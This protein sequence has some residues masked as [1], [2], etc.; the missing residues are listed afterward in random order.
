LPPVPPP[1]PEDVIATGALPSVPLP[2]V[3]SEPPAPARPTEPPER[4]TASTLSLTGI[5][6]PVPP[7]RPA[8]RIEVAS[9]GPVTI[10]AGPPVEVKPQISSEQ[11]DQLRALFAGSQIAT[12]A[13]ARASRT[14]SA[15]AGRDYTLPA[16]ALTGSSV[17][18]LGFSKAAPE[19]SPARFSGP[20]VRAVAVPP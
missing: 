11:R 19:L 2:P 12:A 17:L 4:A 18:A 1:R 20:A 15:R 14:A 9:V 16:G 13:P 5:S 10:P 7:A 8:Q 6:H 3:R